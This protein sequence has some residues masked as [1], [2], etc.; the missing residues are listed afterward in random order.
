VSLTRGQIISEGLTLAGRT[1]LLS[2]ARLWLNIYLE[3]AYRTQDFAWLLKGASS[4]AVTQ[5]GAV[6]SDYLRMKSARL[7]SGNGTVPMLQVGP[8]EYDSLNSNASATGSPVKYFVDE[9][10][11]QFFFW[12]SP[13]TNLLFNIRYYYLPTLPDA[14]D[15]TTDALI[16]VWNEDPEVLIEEIFHKALKY[17]DDP[18]SKEAEASRDKMLNQSKMN[19][20]DM[21]GGRNRIKLGKSFKRRF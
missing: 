15:A 10:L 5:G 18:R 20:M 7:L 2:E 1:D 16:P 12:P 8:E 6:P 14:T 9:Q 19:N 13:S 3:K 17:N 21:R 4:L 11:K